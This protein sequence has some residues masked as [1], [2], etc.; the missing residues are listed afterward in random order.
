[1]ILYKDINPGSA[2]S[3]PSDFRVFNGR[4]Y[5]NAD[6]GSNGSELWR[7]DGS[8]FGISLFKD[9]NATGSSSP[10]GFQQYNGKLYF[11]ADDG[12]NGDELWV[13]DGTASGTVLA[14]DI[15]PGAAGSLPRSL[16]DVDG[17]LLFHAVDVTNGRELWKYVDPAL[18][19]E[20]FEL[21]NTVTLQPNP[22][23]N[24]FSISTN[25]DI[26]DVLI[27]DV[28]GKI[29][30]QFKGVLDQYNIEDLTT[31]LYF[32]NVITDN[33]RETLKLLKD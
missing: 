8:I 15:N 23:Q 14:A 25:L 30:K 3:N 32:V 1:L 21:N 11:A 12:I 33:R 31:G 4:L 24:F 10:I 13:T 19:A 26:Q 17:E 20:D 6:N 27:Y 29:V 7:A 16:V 9:I 2:S 22:T 28:N 18:S 5:F